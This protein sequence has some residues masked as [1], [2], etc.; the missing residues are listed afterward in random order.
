MDI[1]FEDRDGNPVSEE[2][3]Y[4]LVGDESYTRVGDETIGDIR[5]STVWLVGASMLFRDSEPV[6]KRFE[7]ALFG[8]V[9]GVEVV[10]RYNTYD[11]ALKG[12]N[13]AVA[14]IKALGHALEETFPENVRD[15]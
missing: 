15:V 8:K 11:E 13:D 10:G 14:G 1:T 6:S 5:V 2:H 7:T 4:R 12:H 9:I 3:F